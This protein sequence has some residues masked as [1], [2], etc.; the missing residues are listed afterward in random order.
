[1]RLLIQLMLLTLVSHVVLAADPRS[2]IAPFQPIE[3]SAIQG[4]L[5]VFEEPTGLVAYASISAG[6]TGTYEVTL[7]D[8]HCDPMFA[9]AKSRPDFL[10]YGKP[11]TEPMMFR[12]VR[13][14]V[15]IRV[16]LGVQPMELMQNKTVIV[17][18]LEE[19]GRVLSACG[20]LRGKSNLAWAENR[21]LEDQFQQV[22]SI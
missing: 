12:F 9:Q 4:S 8:G 10:G 16:A 17:E 13:E 1:M 5:E 18:R 7:T 2:I 20:Q 19:S 14:P 6:P 15:G 22:G 3:A 21:R 11:L